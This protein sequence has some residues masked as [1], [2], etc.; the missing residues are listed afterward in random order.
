M[1]EELEG[2]AGSFAAGGG[3]SDMDT[4]GLH[5]ARMHGGMHGGPGNLKKTFFFDQSINREINREIIYLKERHK[6][7]Q[8]YH[9]HPDLTDIQTSNHPKKKYG[10][11]AKH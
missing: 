9:P 7:Y 10:S 2:V 3:R 6:N 1:G 11:R 8:N 5:D 4:A